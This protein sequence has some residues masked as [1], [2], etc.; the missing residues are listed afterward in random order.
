[1]VLHTIGFLHGKEPK[2]FMGVFGL[3]HWYFVHLERWEGPDM[4]ALLV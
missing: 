3:V 4:C 2:E 1:M